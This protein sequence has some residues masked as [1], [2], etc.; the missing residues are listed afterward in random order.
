MDKYTVMD[1]TREKLEECLTLAR[2]A[3]ERRLVVQALVHLADL[4]QVEGHMSKAID[5][6]LSA[7]SDSL[8]SADK[9]AMEFC[10]GKLGLLYL[11]DGQ[12]E[13]A[14]ECFRNALENGPESPNHIAW[15]GSLGQSLAELGQY[16]EALACYVKVL[17][18]AKREGDIV[19]QSICL[20]SKGNV[21]FEQ[22]SFVEADENYQQALAMSV[23][24][25]DERLKAIWQGN[26]A[27]TKSKLGNADAALEAC[28]QALA[29][30]RTSGDKSLEAA[31]LDTIGDCYTT[32]GDA[33]TAAEYYKQALE[34][35]KSL[36]WSP[37]ERVYLGNLARAQFKLGDRDTA[38]GLFSQAI[39]QFDEQRSNLRSD[40]LKTSFSTR[41]QDL[42]KDMIELC[43]LEG[44]RVEA[45]EYISR[46]KSRA[47][48]DLLGNSPVDISELSNAVD[49]SIAKLIT[50]EKELREKIRHLERVFGDG[51]GGESRGASASSEPDMNH[52]YTQWRQTIEQL[53][54][55]H[56]DYA[57]LVSVDA[58]SFSE[59]QALWQKDLLA[60]DTAIVEYFVTEKYFLAMAVWKGADE[61]AFHLLK[62]QADLKT[63]NKDLKTFLEMVSTEGWQVPISLSS[64]LYENL[65]APLAK[66]L[67]PE[68]KSLVI[69]PHESLYH[70][71]FGA[72]HDGE[73]YLIEKWTISHLPSTSL[74]PI[75][76]NRSTSKFTKGELRYLVSTVSDYSAT[77]KSELRA[78]N[79]LRSASGFNDLTH[80]KQEAQ[81]VLSITKED[82]TTVIS[83]SEVG[84][85][86]PR[87]FNQHQ[88]VHFAG[89]AIFRP[90][91][92]L[93]SGLVMSDGHVLTAASILNS[94]ILRTSSGKLM[95]L[96]ACQ[97]GLNQV[98]SGGEI[99]G[100]TRALMYAGMPNLILSLW[101]V[102]DE[103][104]ARLM[105]DFYQAW[106]EGS[107]SVAQALQQA[108]IKGIKEGLAPH[109][110]APFVHIGIG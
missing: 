76:K 33:K 47:I 60:S 10:F 106:R 41:G 17:D 46:S 63:L 61:P 14:A 34:L 108:Q 49:E 18:D 37:F 67:P 1:M 31:H 83:D 36:G 35:S 89:H 88:V 12:Y 69:V 95:V 13:K 81:N 56:P 107:L 90:N 68:I 74:I 21:H 48:L 59:I 100:L 9:Q 71:P 8:D 22:N 45:L 94:G 102:A 38:F 40:F 66:T 98:T 58:L 16:D 79:D 82:Q 29:Y 62:E 91:E 75:L 42:Y 105:Q 65:F 28:K 24:A 99:I 19:S 50:K 57:N 85:L 44:K 7:L 5:N 97:T 70:V 93:A 15:T 43:L 11:A 25:G 23:Q 101:E 109:A 32:K 54:S 39:D 55:R 73:S 86:L 64:R 92:P 4:D 27:S 52:L 84:K 20:G 96:S 30:A 51:S 77:R 3:G 2:S 72:L 26:I 78:D 110:W 103:S 87:L 53:K 6:L 80:A 104:T